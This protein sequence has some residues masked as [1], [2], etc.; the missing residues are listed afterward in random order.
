MI[1]VLHLKFGNWN[2]ILGQETSA[3]FMLLKFLRAQ[4]LVQQQAIFFSLKVFVEMLDEMLGHLNSSSNNAGCVRVCFVCCV[5]SSCQFVKVVFATYCS[6]W[7]RT[8]SL[9]KNSN[10]RVQKHCSNT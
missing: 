9:G 3:F 5:A 10:T 6:P 2:A 8:V 1:Q 4:K 7:E